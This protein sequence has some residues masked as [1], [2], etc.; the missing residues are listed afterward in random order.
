MT[1][2]DQWNTYA[3][4]VVL[5]ASP[6]ADPFREFRDAFMAGAGAGLAVAGEI[7]AA[8]YAAYIAALGSPI[9]RIDPIAPVAPPAPPPA[10]PSP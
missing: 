1:L 3:A 9:A 6:C 10:L 5:P 2:A 8:Q 4:S 7:A